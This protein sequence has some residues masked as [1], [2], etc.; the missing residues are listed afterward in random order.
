VNFVRFEK[1][2]IS[3]GLRAL[4]LPRTVE[5]LEARQ[6]REMALAVE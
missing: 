2:A 5:E 6:R 1:I 3:G 4:R